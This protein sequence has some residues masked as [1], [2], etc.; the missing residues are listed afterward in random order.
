MVDAQRVAEIDRIEEL[1]ENLFDEVVSAK[2]TSHFQNL[3]RKIT[4]RTVIHNDE[5]ATFLFNDTMGR[6]DIRVN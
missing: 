5:G 4:I 6:D 2:I 3:V 1:K